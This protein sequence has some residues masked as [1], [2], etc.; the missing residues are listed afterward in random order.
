MQA[1]AGAVRGLLRLARRLR[2]RV[3]R[4]APG[5]RIFTNSPL[6]PRVDL[7]LQIVKGRCC[8][9]P[10][11]TPLLQPGTWRWERADAAGDHLQSLYPT[12]SLIAEGIDPL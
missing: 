8:P 7:V 5:S 12:F 4:K 6:P 9:V 1:A 11:R 2:P 10:Y 3:L